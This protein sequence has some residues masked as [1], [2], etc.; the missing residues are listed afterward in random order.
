MFIAD[1]HIHSKYS[2]ATSGE[3]VPEYL[4]LWARRKGID[5]IGTGDFTHPAWREEL[6][7][8]L[9][10]AEEGLYRLKAS[11]R[12]PD[13]IANLRRDPRF[14]LTGEISSIYK[15]NGRVRKVHN[16]ILLPGLEQAQRLARRLELVGNL[17]SD[18]RPILGLDSRDLLEIMLECCPEAVLI[19]AHIWTPHFSMFGAFSGFDTVEECFEDLTPHIRAVETGLSSDP[20]MNWRLSAL[21]RFALISNSDAHSPQKLGR[22]ANLFDTELCYPALVRAMEGRGAPGLAGTIE[23]FPEEGKYHFDGHRNCKVCLSPAEAEKTGGLCPVCGKRLTPGV[24]HRV[25][26]LADRPA[27]FRPAGALPYESLAPLPE[28]IAA[29]SGL[30]AAS[31][32]VAA[33]YQALLHSLGPEFTILREIPLEEIRAVAGACIA[34]GIGRMRAG[35]VERSPGFDGEYG[36]IHLLS[37]S[38]IDRLS[39]Q[40]CLFA[41]EAPPAKRPAPRRA[42]AAQQLERSPAKAEG[43]LPAEQAAGALA[44]LNA[45][46]RAA[47]TATASTIA[48]AAGPGTGKTRTLVARIAY[49]VEECGVPPA[50]ITAVTFT[51]KAAA[52]MRR[53]LEGYF[54]GKRRIR[55]MTIGT[56][57]AICLGQLSA[58]GPCTVLDEYG[59][60]SIAQEVAEAQEGPGGARRLLREISA[61]KNGLRPEGENPPAGLMAYQRRLEQ[62]GALDYD[63]LLLR[64]LA[65][66]EE[67][68]LPPAA[69]R[70][71]THLLVDE[72]QDINPLQRRLVRSWSAYSADLFLIGDPDQAIY[73]FRGA[74]PAC[75]DQLLGE[76]PDAAFLQLTENYRSTPQILRCALPVIEKNG[77]PGRRLHANRGSGPA[78]RL[79]RAPDAFPEAV[80]I[81]KEIGRMVGGID[82]LD[83]HA[84][85]GRGFSDIAI[86][87]RT[88]RQAE[89]LEHCL[90]VEGIP[91]LVNGR[92]KTLEEPAVRGALGF[93]RGLLALDDR[94]SLRDCLRYSYHC[95]ESLAAALPG[96]APWSTPRELLERLPPAL[97]EEPGLVRWAEQAS[98]FLPRAAREKPDRLLEDWINQNDLGGEPALERLLHRAVLAENLAAFVQNLT[99]GEEGDL[100][101]SG[102]RRYTPDAVT[103][104]TLHGAKGLEYPV[105]FLCGVNKGV[106]PLE[107]PGRR[108]DRAEERRLFYVGITRAQEELILLAGPEPSAFLEDLPAGAVQAGDVAERREPSAGKQLSF[109]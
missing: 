20:P 76:R 87:Y 41:G 40:L 9:E 17:H 25:E 37:E 53:R 49:L 8:K 77:G 30:S 14:V 66:S 86:L 100:A 33:R 85:A 46:Q 27:D 35:Q 96:L 42:A 81:A 11:C 105:V 62:N 98:A 75:F 64:A 55:G 82:M 34:E 92:D 5:L 15:K 56:F 39:G 54:G 97:R 3:C 60:L 29:S 4:D 43:G 106:L 38:E 73:G 89:V 45:Q 48:V 18:G 6:E 47:A 84:Q 36:K 28:V 22:E 7:Q 99:L 52:E 10:P 74:D 13:N 57:H 32:K 71:F 72:F 31:G 90:R 79:L 70:A 1:L 21:D 65:L 103:L 44:G 69:R 78:V 109:F 67:G 91:Y 104:A 12:L 61:Y 108:A 2:R 88:H 93:L 83:A 50:Q 94:L 63:D 58:A 95:S 26:Q 107:R 59:A 80:F 51:S 102:N 19:P 101:R 23:F 24:L 16:L 68:G